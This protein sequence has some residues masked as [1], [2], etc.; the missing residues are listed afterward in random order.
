MERHALFEGKDLR[1]RA[2]THG[3]GGAMIVTFTTLVP[4]DGPQ[5]E[6][7]AEKPLNA[8]GIDN[9]LFISL[10][11]HWWQTPEMPEAIR[12]AQDFLQRAAPPRIAG[13]GASMG[14]YGALL[15]ASELGFHDVL[16]LAPQY[17]IDPRKVPFEKRWLGYAER[18][19]FDRD[20]MA[21]ALQSP[22]RKYVLY[23]NQCDD[24][25][26]IALLKCPSLQEF[27]VPFGSH[28]LARFLLQTGQLKPLLAALVDG[29][30]EQ[31][32]PRIVQ[33]A[34]ANRRGSVQ[35]QLAMLRY[36]ERGPHHARL[37]RRVAR[38]FIK[39]S[40]E[41]PQ[42]RERMAKY[43]RRD[44]D[45]ESAQRHAAKF[46]ELRRQRRARRQT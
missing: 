43:C 30:L 36:L 33:D 8:Q 7:F 4:D 14:A 11:N 9:L 16:A 3:G 1:V 10:R 37:V 34:R 26:H 23:D 46:E 29:T 13:Y 38:A 28:S 17:S 6:G 18:L 22:A 15:Y 41:E 44:G 39:A 35:Y 24:R 31:S 20:D 45:L 12:A 21:T 32:L 19:R 2:T 5:D 40:P 42:L 25:K 27:P